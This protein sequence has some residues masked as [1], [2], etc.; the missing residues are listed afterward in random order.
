MDCP[1]CRQPLVVQQ[2]PRL[3]MNCCFSCGGLFLDGAASQRVVDALDPN[4]MHAASELSRQARAPVVATDATIPCPQCA[5]ALE[6]MPIPAAGVTVDVCRE[7]GVWFDRD[8]LQRVVSAVAPPPPPPAPGA[9]PVTVQSGG[10]P[11]VVGAPL[12]PGP[13]APMSGPSTNT[14]APQTPHMASPQSGQPLAPGMAAGQYVATGWMEPPQ[15]A[16][17]LGGMFGGGAQQAPGMQQ[18]M[19]P[20][21]MAPQQGSGWGLGKTAAVVG[22]GVAAVAGVAY[23]ASHTGFGQSLMGTQPSQE[24]FGA[25]GQVLSKLF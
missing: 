2:A 14:Y 18:G 19:Q 8:E 15:S 4:A 3:V 24:G 10:V 22:G 12:P 7:H 16:G 25:V 23:L 1:R 21:G 17:G 9:S 5:R 13:P 20:P 11:Y 6:R